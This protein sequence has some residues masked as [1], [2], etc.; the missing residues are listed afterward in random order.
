MTEIEKQE[1]LWGY[2]KRLSFMRHQ[3][4]A[5]FPDRPVCDITV[6]DIG[7][8]SGTQLGI[9]LARDGY[10]ITGIDVHEA[11]IHLASRLA[12]EI[13]N[14]NFVCN[15]LNEVEKRDFDVVILSEV[16]EHVP[17]PRDLLREALEHLQPDGVAIVTVPNGYGEFEWDSWLFR[18][19]GFERL[20]EWYIQRRNPDTSQ[21]VSSTENDESRHIQFFTL[22]RLK[23]IFED[24]GVAE[25]A[26]SP[27]SLVSG[28][29][30]GHLLARFQGFIDW[31]AR[32]T[33]RLPM[34]IASG[35]Y[36]ALKRRGE[37]AK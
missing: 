30:A 18:G 28:P 16:L 11:S 7:C 35:W 37:T 14:A 12:M 24:C 22:G 33:D 8:G 4:A 19:L 27:A 15:Q 23:N 17:D 13:P 26:H 2:A 21:V 36:F 5:A 32:V 3:I 31:N 25:V 10:R 6:L 34:T 20:V 9:P 1:D 29:F